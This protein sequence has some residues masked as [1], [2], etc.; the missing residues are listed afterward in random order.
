MAYYHPIRFI[1]KE[2]KKKGKSLPVMLLVFFWILMACQF[3]SVAPT[4]TDAA[5][6]TTAPVVNSTVVSAAGD[7]TAIVRTSARWREARPGRRFVAAHSPIGDR[8]CV[9][10]V[11]GGEDASD[12][13]GLDQI[14]EDVRGKRGVA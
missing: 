14:W 7:I 3:S 9:T 13:A 8:A 11:R 10:R 1:H 6:P 12:G 4:P 5:V 2:R